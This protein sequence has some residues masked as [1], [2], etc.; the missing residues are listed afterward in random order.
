[1][2]RLA[3]DQRREEGDVGRFPPAGGQ[4]EP[5]LLELVPQDAAAVLALG[6]AKDTPEEGGIEA[7]GRGEAALY[8]RHRH[9]ILGG[10]GEEGQPAGHGAENVIA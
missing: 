4:V 1:M 7:L 2:D 5:N 10:R 3:F 9:L 8:L 6:S